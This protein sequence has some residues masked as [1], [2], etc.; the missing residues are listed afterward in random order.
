M[1]RVLNAIFPYQCTSCETPVEAPGGL[2][3]QCWRDTPFISGCICDA[4]GAPLPGP[5]DE[6][7]LCD[8]CLHLGRPWKK[9]R[10]ALLYKGNARRI[11]LRMKRADRPDLAHHAAEWMFTAGRGIFDPDA[12]LVPVPVHWSRLLRRRYNQAALLAR[13][14]SRLSGLPTLPDALV[15]TRPT[16][17]Q[18]GRGVEA[19]FANLQDAIAPH[20][21]RGAR[22][23][24]RSVILVDDVMTTGATLAAATQAC[25]SAGATTIHVLI[26]A[27][28]AKDA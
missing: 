8:D 6:E 7:A 27:R 14:V 11:V 20:P 3:G 1:Q 5:A 2:C 15:R 28:V 19:R 26:L 18:D 22:V 24:G 10:A 12:A 16:P 17:T 23:S 21:R 13:E 4:C 25:Q 9:G